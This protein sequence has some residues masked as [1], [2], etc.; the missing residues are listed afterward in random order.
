METHQA[1]DRSRHAPETAARPNGELAEWTISK[2]EWDACV[3][4][5]R[6]SAR[7][8]EPLLVIGLLFIIGI[9]VGAPLAVMLA[10]KSSTPA[11]LIL[12]GLLA[13]PTVPFSIFTLKGL[14][15]SR[16]WRDRMPSLWNEKGCV[17]PTCLAP[18]TRYPQDRANCGHGFILED[19]PLVVRYLERVA[20]ATVNE[21][22]NGAGLAELRDLDDRAI[23]RGTAPRDLFSRLTRLVRRI[24]A[25]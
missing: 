20:T 15:N 24:H 23:A 13:I 14:R 18:L 1:D 25:R 7:Y 8:L 3:A 19:Q 11:A 22:R 17:C 10:N 12:L 9:A 21:Q 5:S 4:R 6:R 16:R 2:E